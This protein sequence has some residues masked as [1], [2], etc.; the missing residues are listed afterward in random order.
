ML[1]PT[2]DRVLPD[3]D[4][5]YPLYR[6]ARHIRS[7]GSP[8]T[9]SVHGFAVGQF[10]P[11]IS[12]MAWSVIT[13]STSAPRRSISSACGGRDASSTSWPRSS[14]I[15]AVTDR[16]RIVVDQQDR[17]ASPWSASATAGGSLAGHAALG[18]TGSHS[19]KRV[20]L[21]DPACDA[22]P[23]ARLRGQAVHHREAEAGALA[24][25]LGGE[26]RLGGAL[27]ASAS[28][29]PVPVSVTAMQ[30]YCPG[31]QARATPVACR[32][33]ARRRSG[34]GRRSASHRAR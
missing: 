6:S 26:E 19:S 2:A 32:P 22:H 23:A 5:R 16:Q 3:G 20:A 7:P 12:G 30:T 21:A 13:T 17:R 11:V 1:A 8:A 29:I 34:A 27:A 9:A 31:R 10:G 28:S 18:P 25:A 24:G 15:A 4:K 33:R 14:S